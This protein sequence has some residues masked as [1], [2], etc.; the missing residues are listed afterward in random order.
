MKVLVIGGGAVGFHI[1]MKLKSQAHF[2]VHLAQQI[3]GAL[4]KE[5][6]FG[7]DIPIHN[8]G[9]GGL[10]AYW[11]GVRDVTYARTMGAQS[12]LID[13]IPDEDP[14][15][16][17]EYIPYF[18]PRPR[19]RM[20]RQQLINQSVTRI[21]PVDSGVLVTFSNGLD[22]KYS[23]IFVCHGAL[24]ESDCLI[25][26]GLATPKSYV[27]DHLVFRAFAVNSTQPML[28]EKLRRKSHGFFR[29]YQCVQL[30]DGSHVKMSARP[31]GS[32]LSGSHQSKS[33]YS[34]SAVSAALQLVKPSN[35]S[36]LNQAFHLRY[37]FGV[38]PSHYDI[39]LQVRAEDIYEKRQE[40][41]S[42]NKDAYGSL[43]DRLMSLGNIDIES[44][45]SGIHFHNIY[46]DVDEDVVDTQFKY[47]GKRIHLFSPQ[48]KFDP[49]PHHFTYMLQLKST[50]I[51][52]RIANE[53]S[54][55]W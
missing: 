18:N 19:L 52:K 42:L 45:G 37:G 30:S 9:F 46:D 29:T 7:S 55:I 32:R 2:D 36:L 54:C 22:V 1:F 12:D 13:E 16:N 5:H 53:S 3:N 14:S 8:S 48:Y 11:H 44:V 15:L 43:R 25:N 21:R 26:S 28:V 10:G 20:C 23:H 31:G 47:S 17:W 33:I 40:G 38:K 51:I 4:K 39:F 27:S 41:F 34:G 50:D 35:W 6:L 24:P 49:G